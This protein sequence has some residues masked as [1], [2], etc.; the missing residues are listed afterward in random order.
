MHITQPRVRIIRALAET[1]VPLGALEIQSSVESSGEKVDLA[2]VYRTLR[3]LMERHLV[4]YVSGSDGYR[5]CSHAGDHEMGVEHA[6]C[7]A[8]GK[9]TELSISESLLQ[10]TKL[11]LSKAG[12]R[13]DE[14]KIEARGTCTDCD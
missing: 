11:E 4:H 6:I 12:F 1:P 2:S 7:D 10:A 9:V 3:I 5:A 13:L 8:C 14:L